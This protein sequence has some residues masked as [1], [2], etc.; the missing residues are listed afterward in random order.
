M[1]DSNQI[2]NIKVVTHSR[3]NKITVLGQNALCVHTSVAPSDGKANEMVKKMLSDHFHVAKSNIQII[4]GHTSH[5]KIIS[6][7]L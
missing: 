1:N 3:Q 6:I 7:L 5:N 4:K 2:F